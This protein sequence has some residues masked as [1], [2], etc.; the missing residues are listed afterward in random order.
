M[1]S[2]CGS[3]DRLPRRINTAIFGPYLEFLAD[4][5]SLFLNELVP[6]TD[7]LIVPDGMAC[8][9]LTTAVLRSMHTQHVEFPP[10][11]EILLDKEMN[12]DQLARSQS[13]NRSPSHSTLFITLKGIISNHGQSPQAQIKIRVPRASHSP[14]TEEYIEVNIKELVPFP[15]Q[16]FSTFFCRGVLDGTQYHIPMS[17]TFFASSFNHLRQL[18][19]QAQTVIHDHY[20]YQKVKRKIYV[21]LCSMLLYFLNLSSD[22]TAHTLGFTIDEWR[23][24]REIADQYRSEVFGSF[25]FRQNRLFL[26]ERGTEF[27]AWMTEA[28][29]W[30]CGIGE[31]AMEKK[32]HLKDAFE[33]FQATMYHA[34]ELESSHVS[35]SSSRSHSL[36]RE[37]ASTLHRPLNVFFPESRQI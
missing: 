19:R 13:S 5:L 25:G 29:E 36:N 37:K 20:K 7:F 3:P 2:S 34:F 23:S 28:A 18:S 9:A 21:V 16:P 6:T 8:S 32:R 31:I 27:A 33:R 12:T 30:W 10:A 11:Y 14:I 22:E 1:S 35:S 26:Q 4:R 15:L 17:F 24:S